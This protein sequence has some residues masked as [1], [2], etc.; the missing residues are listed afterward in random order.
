M[1]ASVGLLHL[2]PGLTFAD[3]AS[4]DLFGLN[5]A[6]AELGVPSG[7]VSDTFISGSAIFTN[8]TFASLGLTPG[9]RAPG[10]YGDTVT[11]NIGVPEP[12]TWAMMGIGFAGLAYTG[13]RR[14]RKRAA[15]AAS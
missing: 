2:V 11:I 1:L 14:S 7:Y 8:A 12:S 9:V 10:T 15:A 13:A 5:G 4:G 6:D 3:S